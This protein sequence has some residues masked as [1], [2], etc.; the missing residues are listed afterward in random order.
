MERGKIVVCYHGV[1]K[2]TLAM[3]V[4]GVAELTANLFPD[5]DGWYETMVKVA[6]S[7]SR[8]GVTVLLP[9]SEPL[10]DWLD[11]NGTAYSAVFPSME[12]KDAWREMLKKRCD[13]T[14]DKKHWDSYNATCSYES[15][16]ARMMR[17]PSCKVIKDMDYKLLDLIVYGVGNIRKDVFGMFDNMVFS[18]GG[19]EI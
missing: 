6:V 19:E 4:K 14:H 16:I 2:T 10:M 12:M 5:G 15:D 18:F 3:S 7:L 17:S 11:E 8:Q 9:Y 1:G 13:K